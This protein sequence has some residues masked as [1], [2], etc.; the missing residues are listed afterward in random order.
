MDGL[1]LLLHTSACLRRAVGTGLVRWGREEQE[2]AVAVIIEICLQA[3][4]AQLY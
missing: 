3:V 1:T 2:V 4:H